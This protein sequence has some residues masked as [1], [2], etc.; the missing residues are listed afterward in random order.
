MSR[1]TIATL[2]MMLICGMSFA[3]KLPTQRNG[4]RSIAQAMESMSANAN[5]AA[6][7][8]GRASGLT[9]DA[10]S[11]CSYTFTSPAT[12]SEKYVQFCVTANGN[13]T[14]FQSPAGIESIRVGS[15]NEGYGVCD[16]TSGVAYYDYADSGD[17]GNWLPA[18]KLG[19]TATSVKI[20]RTT[21]DGI[22][23]LTQTITL[24]RPDASAYVSMS[25]KNNTAVSRSAELIRFADVDAG[26]VYLNNLDGT[27]DAA[28]GYN[29]I[30]G[31]HSP[32]YGLM[33]QLNGP[34]AFPHEGFAINTPVG[35][36]PCNSGAN[37]KGT[38]TAADGGIVFW[39]YLG[40]FGKNVT[41]TVKEKYGSF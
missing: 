28:W 23:T 30:S 7:Q 19:Q 11:A 33:L 6:E 9:A 14:E 39:Q 29:P 22:W 20:S 8:K 32:Y 37:W 3:Q 24:A 26:G 34:S 36:N 41:K 27:N 16:D 5:A 13:I 38:L 12:A 35:P 15:F 25:L 4:G 17:S 21:I 2:G 18:Q 1:K 10:T 40:A 31:A